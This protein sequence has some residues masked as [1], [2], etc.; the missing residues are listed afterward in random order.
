MAAKRVSRQNRVHTLAYGTKRG[1]AYFSVQKNLVLLVVYYAPS[2]SDLNR[3]HSPE[4]SF[5]VHRTRFGS[6]AAIGVDSTSANLTCPR[7]RMNLP[8]W[9]V[10]GIPWVKIRVRVRFHARVWQNNQLC[11]TMDYC[12]RGSC[13]ATH[14]FN[15]LA[16]LCWE[17]KSMY[18]SPHELT[19]KARIPHRFSFSPM[20][21]TPASISAL[22]SRPALELGSA[23]RR[24]VPCRRGRKREKKRDE[25]VGRCSISQRWAHDGYHGEVNI[26]H[27]TWCV[28]LLPY[29]FDW[30][31]RTYGGEV[32]FTRE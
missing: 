19:M 14:L 2:Y 17:K 16:F 22:Y 4:R 27:G 31:P 7:H 24:A 26:L 21:Y 18:T 15:Y 5:S 20:S 10:H 1:I 3:V 29:L 6:I 28:L 25:T 32:F 13:E 8:H 9:R 11:S 23:A 30:W 12:H